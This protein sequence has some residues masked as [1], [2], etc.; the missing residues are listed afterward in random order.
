VHEL[1]TAC[2][3][4]TA[5]KRA[6]AALPLQPLACLVVSAHGLGGCAMAGSAPHGVVDQRG[7]HF[8][9]ENLSVHD[10]SI[11]P[12]S[13]GTNPQLTI[14]ALAARNAQWLVDELVARPALP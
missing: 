2:T 13:L 8:W 9:L 7:R 6:I 10:G 4:W 3:R 11:L 12:T 1:A 5:A 14:Y